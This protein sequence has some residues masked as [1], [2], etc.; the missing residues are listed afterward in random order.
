[1]EKQPAKT[2]KKPWFTSLWTAF[3]LLLGSLLSGGTALY[4]GFRSA[5]RGMAG[6]HSG[7]G[8]GLEDVLIAVLLVLAFLLFLASVCV[9]VIAITEARARRKILRSCTQGTES[10]HAS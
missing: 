10:D 1:M 3:A 4:M 7:T 2:F 8:S 9:L 6:G 5:L